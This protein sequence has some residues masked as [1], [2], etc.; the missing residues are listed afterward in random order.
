MEPLHGLILS[1]GPDIEPRRYGASPGPDA[2]PSDEDRD[3]F[4]L[5]ILEFARVRDIPV[6]GICRGMQMLNVA[7]GGTLDQH[8]S[9]ASRHAA[10]PGQ[11]A[12]HDVEVETDS[13]LATAIGASASVFSY[14][15][16]GIERLGVNLRVAARAADD[17]IEA[18]DEPTGQF[19]IGV[20]WHPEMS[21]DRALFRALVEAPRI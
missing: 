12:E 18:I 10:G 11:F 21:P 13:R 16:Q 1:G 3:A 15:H 14:H 8:L 17:E 5:G 19:R 7:S 9:T 2:G 4:E 20:L 6:L